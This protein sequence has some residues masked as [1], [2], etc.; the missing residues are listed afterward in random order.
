[1]LFIIHQKW[2]TYECNNYAWHLYETATKFLK[3]N[4]KIIKINLCSHA[5]N[6]ILLRYEFLATFIFSSLSVKVLE[7]YWEDIHKMILNFTWKGKRSRTD[8]IRL[9]RYLTKLGSKQITDLNT[10]Y[11]AL[12]LPVVCLREKFR[13]H[14][15][16][17]DITPKAQLVSKKEKEKPYYLKLH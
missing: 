15:A 10:K 4:F 6:S 11:R 9:E 7:I 3:E 1:M 14:H 13:F 12:K 5:E 17:L 2:N 8:N 16:F